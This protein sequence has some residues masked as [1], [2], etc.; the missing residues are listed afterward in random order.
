[1]QY[2][3]LASIPKWKT[4]EVSRG[5]I[6]SV[7]NST[8]TVNPQRT[9]TVGSFVSGPID[10]EYQLKNA[11]GQIMRGR[12]G[13]PLNIA[14]F[15]QEVQRGDELAKI[16]PRIYKANFER[17]EASLA[18]A[19]AAY[20]QSVRD[21][22][23]AQALR[24]K[25][26]AFVAQSEM[27]QIYFTVQQNKA[28]RDQAKFQLKNSE[29]NLNYCLIVAPEGGIIITRKIEPGQTLAAQFQTPELFVVGINMRDAMHIYAAVDEADIGLIKEAKRKEEELKRQGKK[30][31]A[32]VNFTVDAY[33]ELFKGEIEEIRMNSAIS[34]NI[35]AFPV[36][37]RAQNPDLKLLPGM[38]A[39][40]SFE[41]DSRSD[42]LK[43]PNAALRYYPQDLRHVRPED[44]KLLEGR[45]EQSEEKSDNETSEND[46]SAKER[47]ELRSKRNRRHVWVVDGLFLRAVEV[48]TGL[49]DSQFTE[50]VKGDLKEGQTLVTG[51]V[52]ATNAFGQ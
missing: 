19:Q 2:W 1:M 25:D 46:V 13:Q 23:R 37:V 15:S 35:V 4:V 43:I 5:S 51:I 36:I 3:R 7:V 32:L 40:I 26:D 20:D 27:D 48:E 50:L 18:R 6:V 10:G 52:V 31:T 29:A 47:A 49:S 21:L 14:E 39:T 38:T 9:V 11:A 22:Q 44:R 12:N 33:D 16:D 30:D 17:D 41:V 42:V 24:E 8:G 34:Q 45:V 28:A